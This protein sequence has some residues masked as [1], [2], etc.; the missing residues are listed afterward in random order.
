MTEQQTY[1]VSIADDLSA[2]DRERL[3][4]AGA[5]KY[6]SMSSGSYWP[7]GQLDKNWAT[8]EVLKVTAATLDDAQH[9]VSVALKRSVELEVVD[10]L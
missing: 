5:E 3:L 10:A 8:T 7:G 4:E 1:H 2:E 9:I 6:R